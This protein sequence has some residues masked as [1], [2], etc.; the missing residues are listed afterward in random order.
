MADIKV[1][2]SKKGTV[3][4]INKAVVGTEKMKDK[5]LKGKDKTKEI[6]KEKPSNI[7]TKYAINKISKATSNLSNSKYR[8][9]RRRKKNF[10]KTVPNIQNANQKMKTIK[11]KIHAKKV[12]NK[13]NTATKTTK[14]TYQE[15]PSNSGTEY[16]INKISK[17]I[18]N[19]PNNVY[20]VNNYGKKNFDKTVQNIQNVNQKVKT[21]KEKTHAKKVVN[22]MKTATKTRKKTI[23]TA[24]K[25]VKTTK[26]VAKTTAKATKR[27]IQMAKATAKA[28]AKAI[29][30]GIKAT[31]LAIKGILLAAKALI[32]FLVAGGWIVVLIIIVICLIAMLVSSIF[33]IFFSSEDTGSTITVNNEQKIVTMNQVISEINNEF[34][35]K[36]V[37]IQ[38]DNPY[39]EYDINYS[40][41]AEWKDVLAVYVARISKGKNEVDVITINDEKVKLLKEIFWDMNEVSFTK[42]ES[43]HEEIKIGLTSTETVTVTTVKLHIVVKGKSTIEMADEYNF[44]A[45]QR[46]QLAELTES[47]YASMWSNVIYGSSVGSNDIVNVALEQVGNVGGQPYW[48]WYGFNSRVEWCACFVSWCANQCGYIEAGII[49]KFAGCEEG[50]NWFK[51]WE[52]WQDRGFIAK[53]GDIIFFDWADETGKRN[54]LVDHVGIVE[55][56]E[57]GKVYTIE[58]NSNDSCCRREYDIDSLDILGYG[59]P[60][61]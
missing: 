37:Q 24:N 8:L 17:V 46:K 3:K 56:V 30:I 19:L 51:V 61:Y 49:P 48:S 33:G 20:R 39:N 14:E 43:S 21:I 15:E 42:E 50:I 59:T 54:G 22:K 29:K 53:S 55:K 13:M 12:V 38:K 5:L 11:K 27:A 35:N 60:M 10:Y 23:K 47:K 9:N 18:S 28:T 2:K 7:G 16:A 31:I 6:Y 57:N 44:N 45:E 40:S 36:I 26:Q 34:I 4:T 52:L 25:A 32:A 58:G 1:K 41:K